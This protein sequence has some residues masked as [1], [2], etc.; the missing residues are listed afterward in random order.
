LG[1]VAAYSS[2]F[3][4]KEV[5]LEADK[6]WSQL[7]SPKEATRLAHNNRM[8]KDSYAAASDEIKSQVANYIEDRYKKEMEDY[9][10]QTSA[11]EN[12]NTDT[13]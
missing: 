10:H 8:V 13:R 9:M 5:K 1:S 2:L 6:A 11:L 12:L 3:F 7:D 4:A